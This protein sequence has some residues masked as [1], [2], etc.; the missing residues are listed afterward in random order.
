MFRWPPARRY[1]GKAMRE[2]HKSFNVTDKQFDI[3]VKYLD[4][5]LT[6]LQIEGGSARELLILFDPVQ[7]YKHLKDGK[8]PIYVRIG[9]D[10]FVVKFIDTFFTHVLKEPKVKEYFKNSDISKLKDMLINFMTYAF[11][12]PNK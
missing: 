1:K 6:E 5:S 7:Q 10:K 11:G 12:G 4:K 2:L 9:G 8:A 3:V